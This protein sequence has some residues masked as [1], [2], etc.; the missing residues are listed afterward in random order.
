M[1]WTNA[2]HPPPAVLLPDG[3]AWL[4]ETPADILLGV[5][6][7]AQRHDH[8]I[9]LPVG[10]TVLLYTDGLVETRDGDLDVRFAELLAALRRHRA[11]PLEVLLDRV[12]ADLVGEHHD[13]DVAVL[14]VRLR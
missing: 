9:D 10:S 7:V 6:A 3:A 11:A 5:D 12:L 2:G 8:R 14:G 4:L 13:D 1:H